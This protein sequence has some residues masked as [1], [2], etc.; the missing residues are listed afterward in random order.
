MNERKNAITR[1]GGYHYQSQVAVIKFVQLLTESSNTNSVILENPKDSSD[2][3]DDIT[4]FHENNVHHYQVKWGMNLQNELKPANFTGTTAPLYLKNLFKSWKLYQSQHSSLNHI[5]HIYTSKKISVQLFSL[6]SN[7]PKELVSFVD[8]PNTSKCF[9]DTCRNNAKFNNILTEII[10]EG[11]GNE[12]EINQFFNSLIIEFNKPQLDASVT[13]EQNHNPMKDFILS[14]I[15]NKLG[16]NEKP[17]EKDL[18]QVYSLLLQLCYESALYGKHI[19]KNTLHSKLQINDNLNSIPQN[20]VFNEKIFVSPKNTFEKTVNKVQNSSGKKILLIG[21]PGSGKSWFLTNLFNFYKKSLF[22]SPLLYYCYIN[23]NEDQ[24]SNNRITANQLFQNLTYEI[25]TQYSKLLD[26]KSPK[27]LS[28]SKDKLLYLLKKI[29]TKAMEK[30]QVIPIIIDGLD[31]VYRI[32]QNLNYVPNQEPTIIQFLKTLKVPSGICLVIGTQPNKN[33]MPSTYEKIDLSGFNLFETTEFLKK[34]KITTYDFSTS[35]IKKLYELTHGLPLQISYMMLSHKRLSYT[36]RLSIL[37]TSIKKCPKTNGDVVKYYNWL[38]SE[39]KN[40]PHLIEF[41]RVISL[42]EFPASNKL[43]KFVIPKGREF[44]HTNIHNVDNLS[45]LLQNDKI[46]FFHESFRRFVLEDKSFKKQEKLNHLKSILNFLTVNSIFENETSFRYALLYA[47]RIKSFETILNLVNLE[48]IDNAL[49][50]F[51]SPSDIHRNVSMAIQAAVKKNDFVKIVY[52][53]LLRKYTSDRIE[54]INWEKFTETAI[55]L[56]VKK[57]IWTFIFSNSR[58]TFSILSIMEI[59]ATSI[60]KNLDFDSKILLDWL[61]ENIEDPK[62]PLDGISSEDYA[63]ILTHAYGLQSSLRWVDQNQKNN[64]GF[65]YNV[66][67]EIVKTCSISEVLKI[68]NSVV[69]TE[70]IV[71]ISLALFYNK[72]YIECKKFILDSLKNGIYHIFL[73]HIAIKLKIDKKIILKYLKSY[74]PT[75][76]S[77]NFLDDSFDFVDLDM[78]KSYVS[79]LTYCDQTIQ[80]DSLKKII[81]TF[82]ISSATDIQKLVIEFGKIEGKFLKNTSIQPKSILSPL[83]SFLSNISSRWNQS[84]EIDCKKYLPFTNNLVKSM[85][86]FYFIHS[87][88]KNTKDIS[89]IIDSFGHTSQYVLSLS[90]LD[91]Y[92]QIAKYLKN[93]QKTVLYQQLKKKFLH[94]GESTTSTF[95]S[96]ANLHLAFG[97]SDMAKQEFRNAIK[98]SFQYGYH[99]D[100]LMLE[101]LEVAS[102]VNRVFPETSLNHCSDILQLTP[103]L[104]IVTDHDLTHHTLGLVIEE[105]VKQNPA[106]GIDLISDLSCDSWT[107]YQGMEATVKHL[108]KSS[109]VLRFLLAESLHFGSPKYNDEYWALD[110]RFSLIEE[111]LKKKEYDIAKFMVYRTR[112]I[113]SKPLSAS[114][115]SQ[116]KQ[117]NKFAKQ[118]NEPLVKLPPLEDW[119]KNKNSFNS[120]FSESLSLDIAINQF[121][122]FSPS[123]RLSTSKLFMNYVK[124]QIPTCSEKDLDK[125]FAL[126]KLHAT[127]GDFYPLM[128]L[129]VNRYKK[130]HSKK[131]IPI[132]IQAFENN[133]GW[134]K[135]WGTSI[136]LL[137]D[138]YNLNKDKA[139]PLIMQSFARLSIEKWGPHDAIERLGLFFLKTKQT[140]LLRDTYHTFYL[141]CKALFRFYEPFSTKY[142]ELRTY[143]KFAGNYDELIIQL[144]KLCNY[145]SH[146][147]RVNFKNIPQDGTILNYKDHTLSMILKEFAK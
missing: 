141:F 114:G 91:G 140:T 33:V 129:I 13:E 96:F 124:K 126:R 19:T 49:I 139:T 58:P 104:D 20:F 11:I 12:Q 117:F 146:D 137:V 63:V 30:G 50:H 108:T 53:S 69:S 14:Q 7:C 15:E 125:I 107:Y 86:D 112:Y 55:N 87:K 75:I 17:F 68:K 143:P 119:M 106:A 144:L 130:L 65:F 48:L 79:V 101:L 77:S 52:Y 38:W 2:I 128:E 31:H 34:F 51:R 40:K 92:I 32:N 132:L 72:K 115:N 80:L 73:L 22:F 1:F 41:A 103:L 105:V 138:S 82:P 136:S 4:F 42:L 122:S 44:Y 8:D 18:E 62:N 90:P 95:L 109:I 47:Y 84:S 10:T 85:I 46:E 36:K 134:S 61:H 98:F 123:K 133:H 43:L 66:Y 67:D 88:I 78:M 59:L 94:D 76:P 120:I 3:F 16:I 135:N 5:F 81:D 93:S 29:G 97:D 25:Q 100:P 89:S 70:S 26:D 57:E 64:P 147:D 116:H 24:F 131:L 74:K 37:K 118:L 21:K 142:E 23:N 54:N 9:S 145:L 99:K 39:F 121:K 110:I 45:P 35:Q 102:Y 28:S 27:I 127:G 113:F 56:G 111:A 83:Q 6:L 60:R 71:I